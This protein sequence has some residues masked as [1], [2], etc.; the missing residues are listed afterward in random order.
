MAL[1]D[2]W[3]AFV[4]SL[5]KEHRMIPL[6]SIEC[7]ACTWLEACIK[8]YEQYGDFDCELDRSAYG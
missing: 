2:E 3:A 4:V 8:H 1:P 7:A 5:D 6:K